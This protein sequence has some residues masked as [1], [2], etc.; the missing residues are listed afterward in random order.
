MADTI[1]KYP[2]DLL[3]TSIDNKAIDEAHTIGTRVGRIF[4]TD[5][6]PFFGNS[7]VIVDAV[8]GKPLEP[9]KDYRLIHKYKEA[10]DRAG[11]AVYAGVQIVNPDVSTEILITC[12][13]VGGEFS[14]S[15][16]ALKQAIEALQNDDRQVNWGDLVG[17]P[18][19]FVAAPHLHDIYD[20]YGLKWMI[21]AE[22]DVAAAIREGDGASRT[23]LLKQ[24]SD[25]DVYWT[26]IIEG[27][28]KSFKPLVSEMVTLGPGESTTYDMKGMLG[29]D[30][31]LW[32]M[33]AAQIRSRVQDP[34][35]T[36]P[37]YL[38]MINSEDVMT[39]G[40][41]TEGIIT[42]V[43][44]HTATLEFYVRIDVPRAF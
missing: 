41:S 43:N 44:Y 12:Q 23:L 11:Q 38:S 28:Q 14:Y 4:V 2:L 31:R 9:V 6:G 7:A 17:V 3:G 24:L 25:R 42:L 8:T 29:E 10:T 34:D 27:L 16:Y 36:S 35:S 22:Y 21:E 32:D 19:Q 15:Y 39:S 37:T 30:W 18:A 13:Y 33:L 1:F 5:Y 26:G 40:I 20:L